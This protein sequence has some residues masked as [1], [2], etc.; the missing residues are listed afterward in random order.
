MS[1][2]TA[3]TATASSIDFVNPKPFLQSLVG[4]P[5][6]VQLKWGHEYRGLLQSFDTYFNV[7]LANADEYKDGLLTES[8]IG[9]MLVRCNNV[10]YIVELKA[11]ANETATD[12]T[13][14]TA[15]DVETSES[16]TVAAA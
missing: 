2:G 10:L 1:T 6:S 12:S 11:G 3:T 4:K 5:V 7:L 8:S 9:D 13:A 15:M 14:T 16:A